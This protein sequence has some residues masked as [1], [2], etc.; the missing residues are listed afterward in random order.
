MEN[1]WNHW[2]STSVKSYSQNIWH[3]EQQ[4]RHDILS[5]EYAHWVPLIIQLQ[6][7]CWKCLIWC[8][9]KTVRLGFRYP[10]SCFQRKCIML[11]YSLILYTQNFILVLAL[12]TVYHKMHVTPIFCI[13][14]GFVNHLCWRML[15]P[16]KKERFLKR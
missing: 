9:P 8:F 5:F 2:E 1:W 4:F 11:H 6:H 10:I 16:D 12:S 7:G 3:T 15:C 13:L 14:D